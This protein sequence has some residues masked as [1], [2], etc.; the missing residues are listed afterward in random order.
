MR[1]FTNKEL[2][3]IGSVLYKCEGTQLRRDK[4]RENAT[5]YWVIEFTNSDPK[6]ISLFLLF[7]RKIIKIDPKKLKG[8]LFGYGD[9]NIKRLEDNWSKISG[10]P[11]NNFNKTIILTQKNSKYKPNPNGTFKIRYHSKQAFKKLEKVIDSV[12]K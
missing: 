5:Y 2:R 6:L 11:M 12:L 3:I 7:L 4:R 8:Q 9:M 1:H 10:I